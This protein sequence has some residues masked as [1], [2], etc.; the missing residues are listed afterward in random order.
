MTQAIYCNYLIYR[1]LER[2]KYLPDLVESSWNMEASLPLSTLKGKENFTATVQV[3]VPLR[4]F[5]ILEMRPHVIVELL[6]P[7]KAL[8][9]AG[10]LVSLDHTDCRLKM[11]PP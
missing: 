5:S 6:E 7:L 10:Q 8:L 2:F 9:V 1:I 4:V 3:A 11:Y